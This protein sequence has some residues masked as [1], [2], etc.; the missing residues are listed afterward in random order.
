[1]ANWTDCIARLS[2]AAGRVLSDEEAAAIFERI[3]KAALD[4]KA[5][6]VEP[7]DIGLGKLGEKL[8][9][10]QSQD[11]FI[12]AVAERA[13]AELIH[14][15]EVR[16]RQAHL[17]VIKMA[18]RADDATRLEAQ[19]PPKKD[20]AFRALDGLIARDYSGRTN[21]ES[22]EQRVSG[23]KSDLKRRIAPTWDALGNDFLGFFQ[24]KDKQLTLVRELR[25]ED[26]GDAVAKKGAKAF[27]EAAEE[28]R[29]AFNAAG[30]DVGKLDDWG[31]PQ[32]H[33]Q[34]RVAAAGKDAWIDAVLPK[35][36]RARYADD[37]GNAWTDTQIRDFLGKAWDTIATNGIANLQPGVK[38]GSGKRANRNAESRQIH[39]KDAESVLDYWNTFGDRTLVEILDGH[40]DRMAKDIAFIEKFGPNPDMTYQTLRD[41]ALQRSVN[42]D[43]TKT[44]ELQ[45]RAFKSD[46]LYEYAAGRIKPTVN[47][48]V[49]NIA[50][51][52]A[53][54]NS[55]GKLGGAAIASFFGDKVTYEAVSHLN[56]IPAVQR[57][58]SELSLLNPANVEDRRM[59]VR[60]GLMAE[61]VRN[62]LNRFYDDMGGSG[63]GWSGS[64]KNTTGKL[65]NAVMRLTGMNAINELR[66]G[67]FGMSLM[68][69]IG[70]EIESGKD[71]SSLTDSD[72]RT[73]ST[74]GITENDWAVWKLAKLEDLGSGNE[75]GLTPESIARIPDSDLQASGL[76]PEA[77][78]E[79]IVK[80]LG[81]INTESDF[82]IT[83]PGWRE[84][85]GFYGGL[86]RGTFKGEVVRS[87]LQ[88][89][90]FPW[91]TFQ[92]SLDLVAN[93]DTPVGKAAMT[94]YLIVSTTLAGA[95]I[96]QVRD[97]LSG[98][99]PRSMTGDDL[100]RFWA[101]AFL[102]G[103]A[104]GI[105][106]D[107]ISGINQTRYGSG[108]LETLAGPTVGPL[109]ELGLVQPLNAMKNKIEGKQTHLGAQSIQDMKGFVP[110]NNIWY[111]KAVTDHL[112]WQ[113]AMEGISP[114]YL[115]SIRSRSLR[116]NRQDWW[117]APG[118]TTP[119]RA[120]AISE[121][122]K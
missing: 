43:P 72:V 57:W 71:F 91:T 121:A 38:G 53:H 86:Q 87:I 111:M 44:T 73:L 46:N 114:G 66:K 18:A 112:I 109:L 96:M 17:Q 93:A 84:R 26:A 50:D 110:G 3:H 19:L 8:G 29:Q 113:R 55:A 92:R 107:F 40:I 74:F 90:S 51:G 4:L 101:Q 63:G 32:H 120:P 64:F 95:M 42:A 79:A 77:R 83:T 10:G 48:T 97:M 99:D 5:G 70:H 68:S 30:G 52:I 103:G 11:Q 54:L 56:N 6:R 36:D 7:G 98:K 115:S 117:W 118:E 24:D 49:S 82:A 75:K 20:R 41:Q 69:A 116:D 34:E 89:K 33:S 108:P 119:D 27:H 31:M 104:L 76:P 122:V 21:I 81:A 58:R 60:Q 15:A 106:G 80:L 2:E 65:A 94:S 47:A 61:Y 88:F 85:A 23:V 45:G 37:L 100:S 62:G 39:F 1:M 102:Q 13:A 59:L 25:G 35:L 9:I 12:Q 28:A 105:Y 78:R 67:A 22:L 16:E 14:Q